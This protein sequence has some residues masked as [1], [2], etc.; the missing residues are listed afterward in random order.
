MYKAAGLAIIVSLF[1]VC[2]FVLEAQ[3]CTL[4]KET[5]EFTGKPKITTDFFDLKG[6]KLAIDATAAGFDYFFVVKN[7]S[8]SC[9]DETSEVAILFDGEK[10]PQE[11]R[12]AGST[13]CDGVFHIVFRGA[14]YTPGMVKKLSTKKV[15]SFVFSDR[16]AK[17]A[18]I[19][20]TDDQ[21]QLFMKYTT[22]IA[23]EA[24]AL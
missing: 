12:N 4:K 24:K 9:F 1:T 2:P 21:Q 19:N 8:N 7:P 18:I 22:C 23:E 15:I 13:N 16:N 17:K 14:K 6:A 20:L 10:N 3:N 5:D 11:I